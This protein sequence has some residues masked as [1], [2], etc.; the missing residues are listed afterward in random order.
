MKQN[1]SWSE[2]I[3]PTDDHEI[4]ALKSEVQD[5]AY[6]SVAQANPKIE[7]RL[8]SLRTIENNEKGI[9]K[10]IVQNYRTGELW[11]ETVPKPI[12]RNGGVL[13]RNLYSVVS[14]GTERMKVEQAR[15]NLLEKAKARPDQVRKVLQS[16]SQVGL[17][18]TFS[19][20]QERLDALTPLGYSSVGVVE[21]Y[22]THT[23]KYFPYLV[24]PSLGF[25][26]QIHPSLLD[27]HAFGAG[28]Y[29]RIQT[30]HQHAAAA[31]NR[32]WHLF[33]PELPCSVILYNLLHNFSQCFLSVLRRA[34]TDGI[35]HTDFKAG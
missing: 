32:F 27:L 30:P 22:L 19:K 24:G 11:L 14:T 25:L 10:Q 23:L 1:L 29:D 26:E 21:T 6:L 17:K 28:A 15:M 16:V 2:R 9:V 5:V 31:A 12:C 20:V 3:H 34:K 7:A 33:Q 13:V 35:A 4:P 18:D 8:S